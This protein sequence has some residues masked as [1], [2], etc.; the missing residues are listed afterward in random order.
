MKTTR[1]RTATPHPRLEL[2][3]Y[4]LTS[5]V[6]SQFVKTA[7][8]KLIVLLDHIFIYEVSKIHGP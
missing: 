1:G 3:A 2:A 4:H 6:C 7:N 5:E 8:L